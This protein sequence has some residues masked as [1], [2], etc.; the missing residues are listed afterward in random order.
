MVTASVVSGGCEEEN[1]RV[2]QK[3]SA[4]HGGEV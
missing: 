3:E 4:E 1:S 2:V